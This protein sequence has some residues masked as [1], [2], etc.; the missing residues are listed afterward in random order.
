M[1]DLILHLFF[2]LGY[3]KSGSYLS[4]SV[5]SPL[6]DSFRF[7]V[8]LISLCLQNQVSVS[9]LAV[10]W[11]LSSESRCLPSWFMASSL[12][13][14]Q[15]NFQS[16]SCFLSL[17]SSILLQL[18]GP[19]LK[20]FFNYVVRLHPI[21]LFQDLQPQ[22]HLQN[23]FAM[24]C[25]IFMG[26]INQD[27]GICE[28]LLFSFCFSCASAGK[29]PTCSA[30]DIGSIPGLQRS[31]GEGKGYPLQ[32]SGLENS[33]DCIV[34]RVAKSQTQLSNFQFHFIIQFTKVNDCDFTLL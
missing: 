14:Q 31:P 5:G 9:L 25:N 10:N 18:S 29:E 33:L 12:Q 20:K 1:R 11:R 15:W 19:Y 3:H 4:G 26:F 24:Q 30:G 8:E 16:F 6:A 13:C 22:L 21:F 28:G 27:M 32:Y 7:L 2:C 17:Y 23:L 34:H